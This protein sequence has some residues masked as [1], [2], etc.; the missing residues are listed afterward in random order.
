MPSPPKRRHG[1]RGPD[2][3]PRK[4]REDYDQLFSRIANFVPETNPSH[5]HHWLATM[6][7]AKELAPRC[8]AIKSDG[9]KCERVAMKGAIH[10]CRHIPRAELRRL[11]DARYIEAQQIIENVSSPTVVRKA[12]GVQL[13]IELRRLRFMWCPKGANAPETVG[14]TLF[15]NPGDSTAVANHLKR[16]SGVDIFTDKMTYRCIDRCRWAAFHYL[17]GRIDAGMYE[18]RVAC[19][20]R[21]DAKYWSLKTSSDNQ[22]HS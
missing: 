17:L 12:R 18:R 14:A 5:T 21:Q 22:N 4:R 10:C 6:R 19:A 16:Y 13:T 8:T 1:Q 11:D 9:I 3:K 15:L 20:L 2:K 7:A